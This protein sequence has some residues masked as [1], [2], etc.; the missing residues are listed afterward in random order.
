MFTSCYFLGIFNE[1]VTH[2][3]REQILLAVITLFG[4]LYTLYLIANVLSIFG[5]TGFSDSFYEHNMSV[6]KDYM[7]SKGLP[8]G[9]RKRMLRYYKFKFQGR[10]FNEEEIIKCLSKKLRTELFLFSARKLFEKVPIF[11]K[12]HTFMLGVLIA[13]MNS[14]IYS[15]KD[16][17]VSLG[18]NPEHIHFIASGTVAIINEHKHEL[19]H[20][21]DSDDFGG[22][23]FVGEDNRFVMVAVE[24]TEVFS[25]HK[26]LFLQL[27]RLYPNVMKELCYSQ[28]ERL[29]QIRKVEREVEQERR[30]VLS[31]LVEGD[32]HV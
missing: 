21:E 25:I 3:I 15:A 16:V 20:L 30:D 18:F 29:N 5:L 19:C 2:S 26:K 24:N 1:Y 11:Q 12:L 7:D 10:Y 22:S 23:F 8:Y 27:M 32:T 6:L 13:H 17:I 9:L 4:R 28:M 31:G 14:D